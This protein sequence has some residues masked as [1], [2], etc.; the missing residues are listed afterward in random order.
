MKD[1]APDMT[2]RRFGRLAVRER[3]ANDK[4]GNAK[5]LCECDCGQQRAVYAQ[6]LRSGATQSCGCLNRERVSVTSMR[7]GKSHTAYYKAWHAMIRR[8]TDPSNHKWHRYGGRGIKVCERWKSFEAFAEDMGPRGAGM[9]LDR[10]NNDGDY[11]PSNCRWATQKQQGNNR[12]NNRRIAV[13][14][15]TRTVSEAAR[16]AGLSLSTLR[17]R[18]RSGW[19]AAAA[20]NTPVQLHKGQKT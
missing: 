13:G 18:L 17:G 12:G 19:T 2:G 3:A 11:E 5:W 20:I 10:K 9:T 16:E 7:H 1:K 4:A 8:C 6:A 14:S 15:G